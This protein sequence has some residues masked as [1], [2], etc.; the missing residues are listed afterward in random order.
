MYTFLSFYFESIG[1]QC[2]KWE[3]YDG[4]DCVCADDRTARCS[5]EGG[6][7][8]DNKGK[9]YKSPCYFSLKICQQKI[10]PDTNI[11][12]CGRFYFSNSDFILFFFF[13][14][15]NVIFT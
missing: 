9:Q 6:M 12:S 7:V 11:V 5:D 15:V 8:C 1:D 2:P 4:V 13:A 10:G 3:V 14:C